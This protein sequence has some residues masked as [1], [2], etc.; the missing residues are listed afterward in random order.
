MQFIHIFL[1]FLLIFFA[2]DSDPD[3]SMT[4]PEFYSYVREFVKKENYSLEDSVVTAIGDSMIF[5]YTFYPDKENLTVVRQ[6]AINV[7]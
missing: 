1:Y 3:F 4:L 2:D 6:E 5:E 7:S